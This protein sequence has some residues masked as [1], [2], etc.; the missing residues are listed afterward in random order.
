MER[1]FKAELRKI[2]SYGKEEKKV[3]IPLFDIYK[4]SLPVGTNKPIICGVTKD[5]A[6]RLLRR[7]LKA[8]AHG[9]SVTYYEIVRAGDKEQSENVYLNPKEMVRCA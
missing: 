6:E 8:K 3:T 5:E 4:R 1:D 2:F 9:A 7:Q